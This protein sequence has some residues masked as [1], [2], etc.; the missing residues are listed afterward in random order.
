MTETNLQR[1]LRLV[2]EQ[3]R[4]EPC[5]NLLIYDCSGTLVP[6]LFIFVIDVDLKVVICFHLNVG[7]P[8]SFSSPH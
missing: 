4:I 1:E 2:R 8:L 7:V 3:A 6:E 5:D